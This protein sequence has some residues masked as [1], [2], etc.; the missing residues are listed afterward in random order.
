MSSGLGLK[1]LTLL[2]FCCKCLLY[3]VSFKIPVCQR[4]LS[5]VKLKW[6]ELLMKLGL[7]FR[8]DAYKVF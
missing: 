1:R 8:H 2:A 6:F 5:L 7:S 4:T 3:S